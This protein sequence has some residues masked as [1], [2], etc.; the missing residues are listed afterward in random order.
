MVLKGSVALNNFGNCGPDLW[1]KHVNTAC[2]IRSWHQTNPFSRLEG[3]PGG[4][5]KGWKQWGKFVERTPSH[6]FLWFG[7]SATFPCLYSSLLQHMFRWALSFSYIAYG[8]ISYK[9]RIINENIL[10]PDFRL[11][12]RT[13]GYGWWDFKH[14]AHIVSVCDLLFTPPFFLFQVGYSVPT[15][16]CAVIGWKPHVTGR[17]IRFLL[18]LHSMN[19]TLRIKVIQGLS[20]PV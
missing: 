18:S 15:V 7:K 1:S 6:G 11:M 3:R 2:R 5:V 9:V 8:I 14:F 20:V 10:C 17:H 19:C 12:T 4:E 16:L 13:R